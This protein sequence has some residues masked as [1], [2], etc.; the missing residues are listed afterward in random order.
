MGKANKKMQ[1]KI[2]N[3]RLKNELSRIRKIMTKNH[4]EN[5]VI[6]ELKLEIE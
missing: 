3:K 2:E 1:L 4:D 5:F 6:R